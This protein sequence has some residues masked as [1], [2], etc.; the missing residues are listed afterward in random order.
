MGL[1][2]ARLGGLLAAALLGTWVR[3]IDNWDCKDVCANKSSYPFTTSR[4]LCDCYPSGESMNLLMKR[5]GLSNL[6]DFVTP[7]IGMLEAIAIGNNV[8]TSY[9]NCQEKDYVTPET[10]NSVYYE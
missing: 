2:V 7:N 10:W 5:P 1:T 4:Y 6:V 3:T 9:F 8:K